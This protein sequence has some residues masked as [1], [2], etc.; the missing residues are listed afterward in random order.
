MARSGVRGEGARPR[1]RQAD[2]LGWDD[3]LYDENGDPADG[4]GASGGRG[5]DATG[6]GSGS[7]SR[8]SGSSGTG[9]DSAH[10]DGPGAGSD[11][12]NG[13][14]VDKDGDDASAEPRGHDA[15]EVTVENG[16]VS[17]RGEVDGSLIPELLESIE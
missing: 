9:G 15:F 17:V 12:R 1:V 6:Q 5:G 7:T 11:R 8:D 14:P 3:S 10:A 4:G 2:D 16:V 13:R